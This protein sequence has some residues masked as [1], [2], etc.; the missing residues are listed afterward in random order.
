MHRSRAL[1]AAIWLNVAV[2]VASIAYAL[3]FLPRGADQGDGAVPFPVIVIGLVLGVL[4]LMSSYGLWRK[5]RWALVL[6]LVVQVLQI[7][8]GAPGVAFG[9]DAFIRISSVVLLVVNVAVVVLL[10]RRSERVQAVAS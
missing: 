1:L 10:L 9:P 2:A 3:V 4:G 5:E 8:T 7:I 6:T